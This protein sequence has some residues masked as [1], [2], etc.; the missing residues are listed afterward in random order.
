MAITV[1]DKAPDFELV[2]MTADGPAHLRLSDQFGKT[3]TLLLFVPAA[4][5]GVCTYGIAYQS[6]LPEKNLGF[7]GVAKRSAFIVDKSG[8]VQY[9]EVKE[10]PGDLPD[11]EAIKAKLGEMG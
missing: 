5:T 7:G 11:F 6:F 9:A 3:S 2:T 8:T 4:F 10:S 1:G